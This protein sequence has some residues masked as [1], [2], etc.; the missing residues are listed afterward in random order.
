MKI[1]K[2][3]SYEKFKNRTNKAENV[4]NI[5]IIKS[6]KL[7]ITFDETEEDWKYISNIFP[8]YMPDFLVLFK[9]LLNTK[10]LV[11]PDVK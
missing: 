10:R 11:F 6:K 2:R 7:I 1:E 3:R 8:E 5:F 4:K 9:K